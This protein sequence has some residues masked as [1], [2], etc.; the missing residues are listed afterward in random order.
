MNGELERNLRDLTA[1]RGISGREREVR[2][3][4]IREIGGTAPYRVDALGN[5]LVEKKGRRRAPKK[6]MFAAHMDEVGFVVTHIGENGFL[7]LSPVGGIRPETA[8]GR[9]VEIG[10]PPVYGVIGCRPVHLLEKEAAGDP[11]S[12]RELL[13]DIGA[14]SRAAAEK[15]SAVGDMVTFASEYTDLGERRFAAR[16]VDGR[17]GCAL[18]LQLI[19]EDLDC[20]CV[21]AFTVQ[22]EAGCAG[23]RTA[24]CAVRP[25]IAVVVDAAAAGDL[26]GVPEPERICRIGGG[27]VVPFMDGGAVYDYELYR[28]IR[29]LADRLG[30]PN[31]TKEGICGGNGSRSILA[32][33]EGCRIA[34]VSVPA[35]YLHSPSCVADKG[36]FRH[37]LELLRRLPGELVP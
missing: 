23:G 17:G 7:R 35:R 33:G 11:G 9:P 16:A 37:T 15:L 28:R 36:D 24:A 10:D 25:D 27:P 34:A 22:E 31:Q 20:D 26:P 8:G 12:V 2:N 13:A 4:L 18:L 30:L 29:S 21:F 14:D 6:L 3:Y 19:R 32:S 5:L 1:L